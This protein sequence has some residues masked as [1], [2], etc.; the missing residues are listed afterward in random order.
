M[1]RYTDNMKCA[2]CRKALPSGMKA[3]ASYCGTNC[4]GNVNATPKTTNI[5]CNC[6]LISTKLAARKR[7]SASRPKHTN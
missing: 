7:S 2:V 1:L 4:R 5:R 6:T 3:S